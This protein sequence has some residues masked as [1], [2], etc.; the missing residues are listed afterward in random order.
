MSEQALD[1]SYVDP[2]ILDSMTPEGV[3]L[4]RRVIESTE[5]DIVI[6]SGH[7]NTRARDRMKSESDVSKAARMAV[8]GEVEDPEILE[9]GLRIVGEA[10][11]KQS[12]FEEELAPRVIRRMRTRIHRTTPIAS[13]PDPKS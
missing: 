3:D 9:S 6:L 2:R 11:A 13:I 12:Q 5:L 4:V 7:A 1:G 10:K 8:L